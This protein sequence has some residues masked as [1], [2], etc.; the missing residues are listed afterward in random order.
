MNIRSATMEDAAAVAELFRSVEEAVLG[1]PSGFDVEAVRGWWQTIAFET[2]TWLF[3]EDGTL[4][5]ATG[6]QAHGDRAD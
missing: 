2:N 4:V 6:C 5:A 3:E 1:R